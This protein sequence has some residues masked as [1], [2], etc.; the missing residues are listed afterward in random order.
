MRQ[1]KVRVTV[2]QP[3]LV[4]TQRGQSFMNLWIEARQGL[5]A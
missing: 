1:F 2:T 5:G 3:A 4:D